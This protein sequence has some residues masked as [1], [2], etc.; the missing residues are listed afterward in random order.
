[1][2]SHCW[3][4]HCS[5]HEN[6]GQQSATDVS[7]E[8]F[9]VCV[10]W[11]TGSTPNNFPSHLSVF[12]DSIYSPP[13][14]LFIQPKDH[15]NLYFHQCSITK[16]F[17][18]HPL[19][20]IPSRHFRLTSN[21]PMCCDL[22]IILV[23]NKIRKKK[24]SNPG[25]GSFHSKGKGEDYLQMKLVYSKLAPIFLFLFQ[26][27][28]YS[29]SCCSCLP[30]SHLNLFRVVMYKVHTNGKSDMYSSGRKAAIREFF[31]KY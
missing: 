14:F 23:T 27:L 18:H 5:L 19:F 15:H 16:C 12:Y 11:S 4:F 21:M 24:F 13:S 29:C 31:S 7:K 2:A 22:K 17:T 30:S 8:L 9:S 28:D 10:S 1:M 3:A 20:L 26:W 25:I 6:V